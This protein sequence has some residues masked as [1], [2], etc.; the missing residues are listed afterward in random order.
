MPVIP[1]FDIYV[2]NCPL[3]IGLVQ[4]RLIEICYKHHLYHERQQYV[5]ATFMQRFLL[6]LE[7][8]PAAPR[9]RSGLPYKN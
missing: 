4:C 6:R 5:K 8:M 2:R 3:S 1:R 7:P 9:V